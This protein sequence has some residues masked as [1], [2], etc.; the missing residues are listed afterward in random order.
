METKEKEVEK[1]LNY[2]DWIVSNDIFEWVKPLIENSGWRW[3][4]SDGKIYSQLK[5]SIVET[6]WHHVKTDYRLKCGLWHQ[7]MFDLVG[8]KLPNNQK[9]VPSKCQNC[10][11]VVVRPKTVKQLFALKNLQGELNCPSKCGIERREAVHGLYGGY[12]YNVG[13]KAGLEKYEIVVEAV[14]KNKYLGKEI[15]DKIILKKACTEYE[16]AVGD[17]AKWE[18]TDAQLHIEGLLERWLIM[19]DV[20]LIQPEKM[21]HHVHRRWIEWAYANGDP[22]Y[23]HFTGGKPLYPSYS[24]YQHLVS[25]KDNLPDQ[26]QSNLI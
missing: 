21:I 18:I 24:T 13:L 2:Y 10:Y 26:D 16:H 23:A 4:E 25:E 22:T 19:D 17:S 14:K 6:P 1:E 5:P 12:F 3:R 20:E 8:N 15:A 7:I 11:K 9:F